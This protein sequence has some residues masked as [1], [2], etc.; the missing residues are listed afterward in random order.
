MNMIYDHTTYNYIHLKYYKHA[1]SADSFNDKKI[2]NAN[3]V[4]NLFV[5]C[6]SNLKESYLFLK[7]CNNFHP[8]LTNQSL[9]SKKSSVFRTLNVSR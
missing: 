7:N 6:I 3:I 1:F 4:K 8:C 9:K 5:L 2:F